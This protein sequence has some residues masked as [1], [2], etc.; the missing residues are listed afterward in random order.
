MAASV[1][2]QLVARSP[3]LENPKPTAG[4]GERALLNKDEIHIKNQGLLSIWEWNRILPTPVERCIDEM[5]EERTHAQPTAPAVCAWDG[6]L[7][8]R[9]LDQLA[10]QMASRLVRMGVGP[11]NIVPLCFEKSRWM[12][13]A[14]LAVIKAG[15]GFVALDPAL[16]E[17]R[18]LEIVG[19]V[20]ATVLLSSLEHKVLGTRLVDNVVTLSS[21]AFPPLT[22]PN[23]DTIILATHR[24]PSP[25]SVIYVVFTSGSTGTPKGVVIEHR[26]VASALHHQVDRLGITANS[27]FYDFSS[28]SY[29]VSISNSLAVLVTGG[30]LCTPSEQDRLDNVPGSI[31]SLR[32]NITALTPSVA[33]LLTPKTVPELRS[34]I[35][36]GEPVRTNDLSRWK[37]RK[38]I[39]CRYGVSESPA[40]STIYDSS[41]SPNHPHS[42]GTAAGLVTWVV[43]PNNHN[44]LSPLGATGELLLEGPSLSRGYLNDPAKTTAAF[45]Q[46][47]EW[48]LNGAPGQPGRHGRLYKT[49]DL[50]RYMKDGT[51]T[52]VGRK[53]T[54]VKIRG[55]RVELGEI[56]HHIKDCLADDA[57]QVVVE[58]VMLPGPIPKPT[59]MVFVQQE[60]SF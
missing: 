39:I 27:R 56:E 58:L 45:I 9:E 10:T 50:V 41:T 53:D 30:C 36:V 48:L 15:A 37:D 3:C 47:P 43:D 54:Q 20:N 42:I 29:D 46:S 24:R 4:H 14:I 26:N 19:Q 8:Y 35:L 1:D 23:A 22:D 13:V 34:I 52:F 38:H 44:L 7:T 57:Q 18:L 25:S 11:D 49:G 17:R 21:E 5:I 6:E 59:L 60:A 55:Q 40:A 12:T 51:L 32:A 28:Y 33:S 31:R 2:H 16:P